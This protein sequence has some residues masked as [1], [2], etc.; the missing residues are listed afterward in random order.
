M[1]PYDSIADWFGAD[2]SERIP[3]V[4]ERMPAPQCVQLAE[5]VRA[6]ATTA[7][8]RVRD[9]KPGELRPNLTT[10]RTL[11]AFWGPGNLMDRLCSVLSYAH[12]AT[13]FD[14]FTFTIEEW[15]R[16]DS[17]NE[18]AASSPEWLSRAARVLVDLHTFAKLGVLELLPPTFT[19]DYADGLPALAVEDELMSRYAASGLSER[20]GDFNSEL[21]GRHPSGRYRGY[22]HLWEIFQ[23]LTLANRYPNVIQPLFVAGFDVQLANLL[24]QGKVA[25]TDR[26]LSDLA[27][28]RFPVLQMTP[29][30]VM[31]LRQMDEYYGWR[32]ALQG[33]LVA[34]DTTVYSVADAQALVSDTLEPAASAILKSL[35]SGFWSSVRRT[36]IERL[37]IGACASAASALAGGTIAT[38][39]ASG[40]A[41]AVAGAL[42]S[43]AKARRPGTSLNIPFLSLMPDPSGWE[44]PSPIPTMGL[45]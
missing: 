19:R 3:D 4:I 6:Q 12:S 8:D 18:W 26:F 27:A 41:G 20:I 35:E 13:A 14:P 40:V 42:W 31:E 23:D 2:F 45:L 33:A 24:T 44:A 25:P 11:D 36:G 21:G 15:A 10:M 43:G 17:R 22:V 1:F 29:T 28:F 16:S 30:R 34:V 5:F 32:A 37:A 7:P 39:A 38:S 9:S